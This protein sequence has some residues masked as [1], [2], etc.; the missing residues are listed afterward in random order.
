MR[1]SIPAPG[2]LTRRHGGNT[3]C[4]ELRCG[5]QRLIFDVGS[6]ARA[7]GET[8]R[9]RGGLEAEI[10]L[11]H[12]HYDHLQGLP[13]FAPMFDARNRFRVHGPTRGGREVGTI[14]A[15][16]MVPP[17]FPVTAE[18]VFL[19]QVDYRPVAESDVVELGDVRV[20]ALELHHPGG[21]LGY[22]VDFRGGSVVYATDIEHGS[23]A[24]G[25]LAGFAEGADLLIYDAMYTPEEYEGPPGKAGW[26][27][28]TWEAGAALARAAGAGQLVLFHHDP[29]RDDLALAALERRARRHWA[30]TLAAREGLTL[31]VGGAR[32]RAR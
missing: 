1:G 14:L 23:P 11:S 32:R 31:S 4:V 15:G 19:A 26:G 17:Y 18:E 27:H 20:R 13:F 2:P 28:S 16:Q 25:R 9:D 7:L 6:G 29:A 10:F 21:A 8:L 30:R 24:D 5:E 22:R 3:S 12:Y